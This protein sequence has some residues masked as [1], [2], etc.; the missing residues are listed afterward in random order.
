MG[1]VASTIQLIDK[2]TAP[3]ASINT[4]IN[5]MI[6]QL[7]VAENA[8]NIGSEPFIQMQNQINAAAAAVRQLDANYHVAADAVKATSNEQT[9]LNNNIQKGNSLFGQFKGMLGATA[10]FMGAK[11]AVG[12]IGQSLNMTNQQ[13]RAEQ[14]LANVLANQGASQEDY[15]NIKAKAAALGNTTMY[16]DEALIGGAGELATYIKD[17]GA[18]QKMMGTLSNYAAGMS[19]GGEVN[20]QQMVQYATQLGKALDGSFEGLKK[21][22]FSLSE[23]QE[24]IIDTGTDME[25]ALVIDEVISQ[26][27]A[28]LAEQMAQTPE[29]MRVSM[30]NAVADIRENFGA[31]LYPTILN[32]M[33]T[34]KEN[35]PM[36]EQ[37]IMS[38]VPPIEAIINGFSQVA[39]YAVKA[40]QL[41]G[42]NWSWLSPI[43]IG[44]VG[45]L[46]L[47]NT[48]SAI[49]AAKMA[50]QATATAVLAAAKMALS[51][52]S[53][54]AI[55]AQWGLNAALLACPITWI[56]AGIIAVIAVFYAVI[57]AI[58]HFAGTSLSATGMIMGAF[59]VLAA[60]I[61]NT[62]LGAVNAA[63]QVL[64]ALFV[65]PI[66]GIIE[67]VKN[68]F[69][70]GFN[71]ISGMFAN[72][73]GQ[74]ISKLLDF[75]KVAAKIVD[76]IFGT[77]VGESLT[78]MQN[79]VLQWGKNEN[80]VTMD[81]NAP[82]IGRRMEYG[83]TWNAANKAGENLFGA[84][85][86]QEA[87][88]AATPSNFVN[89]NFDGSPLARDVNEISGNTKK[90]ADF[91]EE[92]LKYLRD[93]A[94]RD[95]IN[96][97]TTAEINFD[98]GGVTNNVAAGFDL[99]ALMSAIEDGVSERL[100]V[101]AEG[102]YA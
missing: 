46:M 90:S 43:L 35:M 44:V 81:R 69:N 38:L 26:S 48:V 57:A 12:W 67:F 10:I 16:G 84:K 66:I 54:S 102:V 11:A 39:L 33:G 50:I 36:I 5:N 29:G 22:G 89:A 59:A 9:N 24:K 93:V 83:D 20:P 7:N 78:N 2:M 91:S 65:N 56:I 88:A 92:N 98:M 45:A 40:A 97:F 6:T 13:I 8:A 76:A 70:G 49:A 72:M 18:L 60:F 15:N 1:N 19:G 58:N 32:V 63:V 25:K 4:A 86:G 77:K 3:I 17:A 31:Q 96:R 27:W 73:L 85:K 79:D 55:V 95:T 99:N 80:A 62:V 53:F 28:G 71:G 101:A 42:N 21:K 64:W 61:V 41:I 52:A 51:K 94:E 14:Q 30:A 75:A 37:A 82:T 34:I 68:I 47:F 100:Q 23:A 74:L 87:A